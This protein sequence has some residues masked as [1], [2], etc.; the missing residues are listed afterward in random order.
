MDRQTNK[1]L[2][3]DEFQTQFN[4]AHGKMNKICYLISLKGKLNDSEILEKIAVEVFEYHDHDD[5][6]LDMLL[7]LNIMDMIF[8][9]DKGEEFYKNHLQL[10]RCGPMWMAIGLN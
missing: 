4:L 8:Y 5:K 10:M 1:Q 9:H 6:Q 2:W 7:K 3:L